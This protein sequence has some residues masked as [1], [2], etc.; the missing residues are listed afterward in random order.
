VA[1]SSPSYIPI[2]RFE[3][4]QEQVWRQGAVVRYQAMTYFDPEEQGDYDDWE[5]G[6]DSDFYDYDDPAPFA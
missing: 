4:R 6:N 1:T 2:A 3:T 5:Q